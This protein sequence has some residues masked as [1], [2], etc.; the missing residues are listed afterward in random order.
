MCILHRK[1]CRANIMLF[2]KHKWIENERF[3]AAPANIQRAKNCSERL[4]QELIQ[5]VTT[6]QYKCD[7]CGKCKSVEILGKSLKE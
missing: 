6:I 5:G 3:Y 4:F 1:D 7:C 2:H